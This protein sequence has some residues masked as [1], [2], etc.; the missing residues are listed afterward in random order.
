MKELQMYRYF[1]VGL[2]SILLTSTYFNYHYQH[3][4]QTVRYAVPPINIVIESPTPNQGSIDYDQLECLALNIYHEARGESIEGQIAVSQVVVNRVADRRFPSTICDVIYQGQISQWY[5]EAKGEIVPLR[6]RC[7]FSWWCD[8]R[9][10]RPKDMR[11]WGLALEVASG[12]MRNQY[13]DLTQ[14]AMWYHASYVDPTWRHS[15]KHITSIDEH[16]FYK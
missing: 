8:G 13:P 14:G 7:Q 9:S 16:L 1:F 5:L 4:E 15:L 12:V 6:N 2:A 11:A 3:A 10:D